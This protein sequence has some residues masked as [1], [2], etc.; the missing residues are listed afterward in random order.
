MTK[1]ATFADFRPF[2]SGSINKTEWA[3]VAKAKEAAK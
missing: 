3:A 2:L 1:A